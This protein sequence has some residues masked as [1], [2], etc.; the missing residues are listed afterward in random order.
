[1]FLMVFAVLLIV[2][3]KVSY[4]DCASDCVNKCIPLGSQ[5]KYAD[6]MENCLDGCLE[7]PPDNVPD[8]PP[9]TPYKPSEEKSELNKS[10]LYAEADIIRLQPCYVGGKVVKFCPQLFPYYNVFSDGCYSTLEDCKEADG[11]LKNVP[12]KGGCV[13]CGR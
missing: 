2:V 7:E 6:C 3:S 12:G 13:L 11:D 5:K 9:P 4:A 10:N 8:V 1:M